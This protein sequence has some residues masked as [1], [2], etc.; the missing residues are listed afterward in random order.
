MKISANDFGL[1]DFECGSSRL[2]IIQY[3]QE[4]ISNVIDSEQT[5]EVILNNV[6]VVLCDLQKRKVFESY[7]WVRINGNYVM[8]SIQF[9]FSMIWENDISIRIPR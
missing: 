3:I 6:S 7:Q 1:Q 2:E 4:C 8:L 5:E 9:L